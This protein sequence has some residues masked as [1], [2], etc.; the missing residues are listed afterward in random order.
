MSIVDK[1][2]IKFLAFIN[3]IQRPVVV[4]VNLYLDTKL[5]LDRDILSG[6][7]DY[8][9]RHTI[10]EVSKIHGLLIE[11]RLDVD[12]C[13]RDQTISICDDFFKVPKIYKEEV[14][15]TISDKFTPVEIITIIM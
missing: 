11:P 9:L 15:K 10:S 5:N 4:E 3:T 2:R 8:L 6:D 1:E 13:R 7:E 14:V 12:V